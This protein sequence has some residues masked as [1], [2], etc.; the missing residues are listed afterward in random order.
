MLISLQ[1]GKRWFGSASGCRGDAQAGAS[2]FLTSVIYSAVCKKSQSRLG[3][4]RTA[5]LVQPG[6]SRDGSDAQL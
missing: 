3:R 4:R 2:W 6:L 5:F 1:R